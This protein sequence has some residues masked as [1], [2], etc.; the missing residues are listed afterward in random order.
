MFASVGLG[1]ES[2]I[3]VLFHLRGGLCH[4][5]SM[6]RL[7]STP[8][9]TPLG[10]EWGS[11]TGILIPRMQAEGTRHRCHTDSHG[12]Q[13]ALG[14]LHPRTLR[15]SLLLQPKKGNLSHSVTFI[16]MAPGKGHL[17]SNLVSAAPQPALLS[18]M[19]SHLWSRQ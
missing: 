4:L 10:R 1:V 5:G 3:V 19:I 13:S 14:L 17:P 12:P 7:H 11:G 2:E 15:N 16:Q 9:P 8:N 6:A 18:R